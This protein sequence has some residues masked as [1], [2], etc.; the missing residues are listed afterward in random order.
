MFLPEAR[1]ADYGIA[2][3]LELPVVLM[4]I[5]TILAE[6]LLLI[7]AQLQIQISRVA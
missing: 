3:L 1:T 6:E 4:S 7:L 2:N 5:G